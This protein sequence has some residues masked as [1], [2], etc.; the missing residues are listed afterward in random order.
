VVDYHGSRVLLLESMGWPTSARVADALGR[1][2][3]DHGA[4][5]RLLTDRG[6]VFRAP[7]VEELLRRHGVRHQLT[8]P[9]HAW[10]N[11]RIER[12]FRT[13]KE[14]IFSRVWLVVS[15]AQLRRFCADFICWY[16][17]D[18][19]H[20][21]WGGRTPDEVFFDRQ[22]GPPRGRVTYFDGHLRWYG[23]G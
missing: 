16:N 4:P 17:R 20:S 12:L 5:R 3:A 14:A 13:F 6:S 2:I 11:G 23:F 15:L 22:P 18:R 1:V 19:P 9:A 8:K 10:T 7:P 21:A